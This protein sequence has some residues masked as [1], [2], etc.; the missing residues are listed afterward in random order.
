M[1]QTGDKVIIKSSGRTGTVSKV[2]A[3]M[4]E[5]GDIVFILPDDEISFSTAA[6]A[7]DVE[8]IRR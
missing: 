3:S 4:D 5:R 8:L 1:F 2:Q 7:D 6:Y